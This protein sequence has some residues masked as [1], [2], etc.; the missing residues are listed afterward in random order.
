MPTDR[1]T[2]PYSPAIY[3]DLYLRLTVKDGQ[4]RFAYSMDGKHYKDAGDVFAMREGKWIGAKFGFVA[5]CSNRKGN[6]GWLDVDW[7]RITK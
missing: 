4:C 7:I 3:L 1:D 2:I 5:E 6:R